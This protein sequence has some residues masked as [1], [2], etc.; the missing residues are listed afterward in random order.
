MSSAN[1]V[2]MCALV[3]ACK[4]PTYIEM[5]TWRVA[6]RGFKGSLTLSLLIVIVPPGAPWRRLVYEYNGRRGEAAIG[7][8]LRVCVQGLC[9]GV[10]LGMPMHHGDTK[11]SCEPWTGRITLGTLGSTQRCSILLF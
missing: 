9:G 1:H 3:P 5:S 8:V 4:G 7:I 11:Y 6:P 10:G 2:S